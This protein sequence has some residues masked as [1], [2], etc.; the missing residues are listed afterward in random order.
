MRLRRV[1]ALSAVSQSPLED[2]SRTKHSY[3]SVK[4]KKNGSNWLICS[5]PFTDGEILL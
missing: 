3:G 2:R 4:K 5:E 1:R